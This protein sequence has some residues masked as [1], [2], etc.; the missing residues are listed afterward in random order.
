MKR[1]IIFA[2]GNMFEGEWPNGQGKMIRSDGWSHEGF[3]KN[4]KRHGVGITT[5]PNGTI[6]SGKWY[7]N[8]FVINDCPEEKS[9]RPRLADKRRL[10]VVCQIIAVGK[11][12]TCRSCSNNSKLEYPTDT[13]FQ[14]WY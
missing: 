9:R 4:G 2:N 14:R 12:R 8:Q 3:W 5:M 11:W 10:C 6:Y 13:I 1:K 7:K